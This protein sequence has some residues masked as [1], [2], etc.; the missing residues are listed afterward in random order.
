M[1]ILRLSVLLVLV[2]AGVSGTS[3]LETAAAPQL[4]PTFLDAEKPT[5][6]APKLADDCPPAPGRKLLSEQ[7]QLDR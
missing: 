6:A 2:V 3:A 1:A 4:Q 5:N 7:T